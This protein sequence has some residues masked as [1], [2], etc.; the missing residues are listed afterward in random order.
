MKL[1]AMTTLSAAALMLAGCGQKNDA[2]TETGSN[3][4]ATNTAM[5]TPPMATAASAGQT[6]A[7]EAAASD[8]FEIATSRA[9]LEKSTSP[10]IK[11]FAQSMIDAHTASTA[12]LKTA[13]SAAAP[14][15]TPDPT[16][17]ADQ[18]AKLDAM[19]AASGKAF[20]Q[21]YVAGQTE[22]HQMTLDKLRA[23]SANGDVPTLKAFATEMAPTVAAHLNMAK[24]LKA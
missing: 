13:A 1:A 5:A 11:K 21:A 4:E 24:G 12:K 15:I 9:A 17:T 16:L 2:A 23:Y 8:A 22:G 19:N 10:A 6:F 3:M 7:N 18:Q 14:A 20:D